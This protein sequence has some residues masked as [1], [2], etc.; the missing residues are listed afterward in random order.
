MCHTCTVKL[1][2]GKKKGFKLTRFQNQKLL[3][4]R[5]FR[6]QGFCEREGKIRLFSLKV[7]ICSFDRKHNAHTS[8][9]KRS[10]SY[11]VQV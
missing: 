4:R 6:R 11:V 2:L 3:R 9:N 1:S 8:Q 7:S 5:R 10:Q